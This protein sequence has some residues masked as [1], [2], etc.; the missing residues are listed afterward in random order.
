MVDAVPDDL[1]DLEAQAIPGD[2]VA[3]LGR[4]AQLAQHEAAHRVDVVVFE[5][6]AELLADLLDARRPG[7][8]QQA[9][10]VHLDLEPLAR[11]LRDVAD[12]LLEE[13]LERDEAGR[14]AVLVHD[15]RHL[16]A[17]PPHRRHQAVEGHRLRNEWQLADLLLRQAR[18]GRQEAH[19][20]LDVDH[21]EDV[22]DALVVDRVAR[23][24]LLAQEFP[25]L[26]GVGPER[27]ADDLHPRDHHLRGGE[28]AKVEQLAQHLRRLPGEHAAL[29][30]LAY[31]PGEVFRRPQVFVAAVGAVDAEQQQEPVRDPVRQ[32][33]DRIE[34]ELHGTHDRADRERGL[35]RLL[36]GDRLRHHL[37][38]DDVQE[39]EGRDRHRGRETVR[40]EAP[41]QVGSTDDRADPLGEDRLA[42][43]A[44]AETRRRDAQLRGR[45][46]AVLAGAVGLDPLDQASGPAS[47][48]RAIADRVRGRRHDREL[49]RDEERVRRHQRQHRENGH[50]DVAQFDH[51]SHRAPRASNERR[52]F[53]SGRRPFRRGARRGCRPPTRCQ[54]CCCRCRR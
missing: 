22:V 40:D 54:A 53:P 48:L 47:R 1:G 34:R 51:L 42:D 25:D 13:I 9:R 41:E 14:P 17:V 27:D 7:D 36:Q 32:A 19:Q 2:D 16:R 30:A 26:A 24:R 50:G 18:T 20:V 10:R 12:H 38:D 46:E 4:P 43:H 31:D 37:A 5:R 45:D 49:R 8:M 35:L 28:F 15:D 39:G 6:T 11:I 33:D 29:L 21:A 44:E 52:T 3:D 23:V